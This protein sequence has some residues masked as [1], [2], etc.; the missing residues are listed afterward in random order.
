MYLF[1]FPTDIDPVREFLSILLDGLE[2]SGSDLDLVSKFLENSAQK[3]VFKRFGS[4]LFEVLVIGKP[5]GNKVE[6]ILFNEI[7]DLLNKYKKK[8]IEDI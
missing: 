2:N 3:L 6:H 7:V 4:Q 5:L 8:G 1:Q